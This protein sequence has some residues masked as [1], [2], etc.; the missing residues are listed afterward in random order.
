MK[1]EEIK[2]GLEL[3]RLDECFGMREG[4]PYNGEPSTCVGAMCDDV[5]A[6]IQQLEA[7]VPRWIS[8]EERLPD[9]PCV[10]YDGINPPYTPRCSI[11]QVTKSS[12][13]VEWIADLPVSVVLDG[14]MVEVHHLPFTHWMP[15]PEPPEEDDE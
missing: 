9:W 15:L 1:P 6:Y 10:V 13:K 3:C 2:K 12:G 8:V 7:Q 14:K 5:L 4:C 11:V